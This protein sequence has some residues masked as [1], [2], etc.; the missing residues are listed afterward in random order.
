MEATRWPGDRETIRLTVREFLL[1]AV[2]DEHLHAETVAAGRSC[3]RRVFQK[4]VGSAF[5]RRRGQCDDVAD[6]MFRF[7][8]VQWRRRHPDVSAGTFLDAIMPVSPPTE[9][10]IEEAWELEIG[11]SDVA[12]RQFYEGSA[13]RR[14]GTDLG[15]KQG[16]VTPTKRA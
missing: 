16:C 8:E 1:T 15:A 4:S 6:G 13:R 7:L 14:R 5:G 11:S 12:M 3:L 10:E 2:M 9:T